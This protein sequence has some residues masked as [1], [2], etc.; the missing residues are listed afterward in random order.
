MPLDSY[1]P[2]LYTLEG[3]DLDFK[4]KYEDTKFAGKRYVRNSVTGE[5]IGIVGDKFSTVNHVNFFNGIKK[6]IQ[7]NRHP[8]DLDGAKVKISMVAG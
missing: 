1:T 4:V 8:H 7:D 6:V 3:T 5:Y 2:N